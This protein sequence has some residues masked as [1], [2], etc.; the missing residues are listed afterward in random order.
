[1]K[2]MTL[3]LSISVLA[4][5]V[6]ISLAGVTTVG[7][8]YVL[9]ERPCPEP[10]K[11]CSLTKCKNNQCPGTAREQQKVNSFS[12]PD[13]AGDT[14]GYDDYRETQSVICLTE[15]ECGT[16]CITGGVTGIQYCTGPFGRPIDA[17]ET[18]GH[19]PSGALCKDGKIIKPY[20]GVE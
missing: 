6:G 16:T 9:S 8:C 13:V 2:S 19:Y 11:F 20:A 14:D 18:T 17:V 15:K 3:A 5:Y 1:M 4:T 10:T 7:L 12:I